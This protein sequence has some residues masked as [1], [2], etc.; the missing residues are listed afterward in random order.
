[1]NQWVPLSL[2][3]IVQKD[4]QMTDSA[5]LSENQNQQDWLNISNSES[6]HKSKD[7]SS[8]DEIVEVNKIMHV[9]GTT[10]NSS[11]SKTSNKSMH[12]TKSNDTVHK[13]NKVD[14]SVT[15]STN[16]SQK[17]HLKY[18]NLKSCHNWT[19]EIVQKQNTMDDSV[20]LSKTQNQI[21]DKSMGNAK[22]KLYH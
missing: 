14:D 1:M 21:C 19:N 9:S 20:I 3:E 18:S 5:T 17:D 6:C 10:L 22:C 13:V 11:K 8:C 2:M 4:N 16:Q 7:C 12:D 15:L